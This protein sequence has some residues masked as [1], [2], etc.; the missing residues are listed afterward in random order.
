MAYPGR[1]LLRPVLSHRVRRRGVYGV[2]APILEIRLVDILA[3][4]ATDNTTDFGQGRSHGAHPA[5]LQ[6]CVQHG[7]RKFVAFECRADLPP[8][9]NF[10]MGR[11]VMAHVN[12]VQASPIA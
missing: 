1:P 7:I 2:E 6:R 4:C 5:G 8:R 11:G 12:F 10:G 9:E 3:A